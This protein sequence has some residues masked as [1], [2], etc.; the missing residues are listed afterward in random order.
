MSELKNSLN[1]RN[2]PSRKADWV[3]AAVDGVLAVDER[4]IAFTVGIGVGGK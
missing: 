3:G 4:D 2:I 1:P